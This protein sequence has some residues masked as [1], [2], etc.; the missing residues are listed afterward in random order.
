MTSAATNNLILCLHGFAQNGPTFSAKASGVRKALKKVGYQTLFLDAPIDLTPEDLPFE[1]SSLGADSSS[2]TLNYRGWFKTIPDFDIQPA[3][4][5]IKKVYEEHGPFVGILGFSQGAGLAGILLNNYDAVVGKEG[6]ID[7][8][9]FGILYSNFKVTPEKYQKYYHPKIKIPTLHIMGELDTLVSNE[10]SMAFY[11]CCEESTA[12][13]L[14]HPGGHYVPNT[15]E[16]VKKQ[17]AWV[18]S[19]MGVQEVAAPP[20]QQKQP[21]QKK[22]KDK[23]PQAEQTASADATSTTT[24]TADAASDSSTTPASAATPA[25]ATTPAPAATSEE[26]ELKKLSEEMDKLGTL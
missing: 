14:K 24:T 23:K 1:A 25:S 9:K 4:D 13:I 11:E 26:D 3:F 10:R 6:A 16:F 17:V 22:N 19:I 15:K 20:K 5:S 2:E 7:E 12:T 18:Q 8:L 21:K